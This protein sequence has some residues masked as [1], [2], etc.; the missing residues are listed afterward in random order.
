MFL[1]LGTGRPIPS[2]PQSQVIITKRSKSINL[3][4]KTYLLED[5]KIYFYQKNGSFS[6]AMLTWINALHDAIFRISP[7]RAFH[8]SILNHLKRGHVCIHR[9]ASAWLLWHHERSQKSFI[10]QCLCSDY[11]PAGYNLFLFFLSFLYLCPRYTYY[12]L[13]RPYSPWKPTHITLLIELAVWRRI[14]S[15]KQQRQKKG[16]SSKART[17]ADAKSFSKK[18][19]KNKTIKRFFVE[20]NF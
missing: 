9:D 4:V 1:T 15:S 3:K 11:V 17:S 7:N 12:V 18:R 20:K 10:R 6:L 2:Y 14:S 13:L 16:F 19:S 8:I 5:K